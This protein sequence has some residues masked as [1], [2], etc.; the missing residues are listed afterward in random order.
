MTFTH[1]AEI[2]LSRLTKGDKIFA[3]LGRHSTHQDSDKL[4][5]PAWNDGTTIFYGHPFTSYSLDE[6]IGIVAN[7]IFQVA[8]RSRDRGMELRAKIGPDFCHRTYNVAIDAI[9][10]ETLRA[11]GYTLPKSAVYL[12]DLLENHLNLKRP[13]SQEAL[14]EWDSEKLYEA[15]IRQK[16]AVN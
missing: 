16:A 12:C 6:Q 10:N 8:M 9:T 7:Q 15:L 5:V 1:R 3:V 2:P 11:E 14:T 13:T 4:D